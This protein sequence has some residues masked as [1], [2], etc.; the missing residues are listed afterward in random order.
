MEKVFKLNTGSMIPAVGL[1]TW[2]SDGASCQAAVSMALK[3]GYRLV[4]CA[5][6]YGNEMEVGNALQEAVEGGLVRTDVFISS[7]LWFTSLCSKRVLEAAKTSLKHLRLTYLDLYLLHWPKLAPMGDATDPPSHATFDKTKPKHQIEETWRAMEA[8]VEQGLVRAIGVS[9]FSIG[10]IQNILNFCKIVP[11][12]YQGELHPYWRQDE[13]VTFCK[14]RGIHV[15]AHTPLG[16]PS[17]H[18]EVVPIYS[19]CG[20]EAA[21]VVNSPS[22]SNQELQHVPRARAKSIHA[23][24]LRTTTISEISQRL[25][26]TAAQVILRWGVQRGTTVLPRSLREDRIQSNFDVLDWSLLD[27]DWKAVNSMEPQ[28]CQIEGNHS[29]LHETSP[30]GLQVVVESDFKELTE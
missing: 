27:N 11:A 22:P 19:Y 23:P 12:V 30:G 17:S 1:G 9:N 10:Q 29:Y 5:H 21:N 2:Q 13:L 20:N 4:D 3:V 26:K 7:K 14:S 6:L 25:D 28:L 24:M 15:V 18:I 8:L 16:V